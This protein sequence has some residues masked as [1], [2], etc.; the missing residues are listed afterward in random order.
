MCLKKGFPLNENDKAKNSI[1]N[2][3]KATHCDYTI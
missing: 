2:I 1:H 3:D